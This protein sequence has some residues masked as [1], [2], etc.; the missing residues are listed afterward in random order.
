[1]SKVTV[2]LCFYISLENIRYQN[3]YVFYV[4]IYSQIKMVKQISLIATLPTRSLALRGGKPYS[5]CYVPEDKMEGCF[6]LGFEE[7]GEIMGVA[8]FYPLS[9]TGYEGKGW[10]LRLMGVVPS[11]Q[12]KGIG[13]QILREG[14]A[15]LKEQHKADYLWCNAREAAYR[16][17]EKIGFVFISDT[18]DIV[19]IGNHKTMFLQL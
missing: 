10:Q 18:F 7:E 2:F 12:G 11:C 5:E 16:F 13:E 6:H 19:G 9:K 17:Y 8:S 3:S 14:I 4:P 1:M 15:Q